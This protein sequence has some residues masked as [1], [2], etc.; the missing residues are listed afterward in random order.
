MRSGRAPQ[1]FCISLLPTTV[2]GSGG[3]APAPPPAAALR[4]TTR[5]PTH[6][7]TTSPLLHHRGKGKSKGGKKSPV[8]RSS[9]AGLQ[10]RFARFFELSLLSAHPLAAAS[11]ATPAAAENWPAPPPPLRAVLPTL[12]SKPFTHAPS[13][14]HSSQLP[15]HPPASHPYSNFFAC[16]PTVPP[17][18]CPFHRPLDARTRKGSAQ[19][20]QLFFVF[21]K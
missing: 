12:L 7:L 21:A 3:K 10:V 2:F 15:E 9:R 6:P 14:E 18:R 4:T 13:A 17:A 20:A 11:Q 19:R 5:H 1:L 8:S 16:A